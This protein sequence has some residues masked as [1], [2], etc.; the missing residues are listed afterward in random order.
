MVNISASSREFLATASRVYK[1]NFATHDFP[2]K[3]ILGRTE[4]VLK[5]LGYLHDEC[6]VV[7]PGKPRWL[8]P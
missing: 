1:V 7:H 3:L 2:L 6:E 5:G 4:Y 8:L